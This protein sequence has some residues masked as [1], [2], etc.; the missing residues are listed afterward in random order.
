[1]ANKLYDDFKILNDEV[2]T[3]K[4]K[5]SANQQVRKLIEKENDNFK[6]EINHL[7]DQIEN[8]KNDLK[9]SEN[10]INKVI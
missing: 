5:N 7:K 1:M 6:L 8:L 2:F 4:E 10:N 3:L 9:G